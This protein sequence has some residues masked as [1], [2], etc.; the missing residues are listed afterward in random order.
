MELRIGS[1][2]VTSRTPWGRGSGLLGKQ[3]HAPDV[4]PCYIAETVDLGYRESPDA[5]ARLLDMGLRLGEV[6]AAVLA[7]QDKARSWHVLPCMCLRRASAA[8][9]KPAVMAKILRCS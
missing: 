8:A 7:M 1:A 6:D 2:Y 4:W 5:R 3:Q 9:H